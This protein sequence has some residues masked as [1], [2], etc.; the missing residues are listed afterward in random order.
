M[1]AKDKDVQH[2]MSRVTGQEE[3][4]GRDEMEGE[5]IKAATYEADK[6]QE[7]WKWRRRFVAQVCLVFFSNLCLFFM[8]NWPTC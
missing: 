6:G 8:L 4:T 1:A 3:R 7:E 2:K 5:Y